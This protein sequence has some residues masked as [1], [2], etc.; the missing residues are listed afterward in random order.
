MHKNF[1]KWTLNKPKHM[2]ENL[3]VQCSKFKC[4]PAEQP[5][6][7][8]GYFLCMPTWLGTLQKEHIK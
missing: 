3:E 6:N 7:L 8:L 5:C 2:K 1:E 4:N